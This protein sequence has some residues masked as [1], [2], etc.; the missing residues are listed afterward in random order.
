MTDRD[1]EELLDQQL[2]KLGTR[3]PAC[4]IEGCGATN[5]FALTGVDPN[6][7]CYE[8]QALLRGRPWLEEHHVAGRS[9]DPSTVL[10]P[11]N[12]HRVLSARQRLW[13]RETLRNP[14][15]SPLLRAAAALRGWL[16][17]L[18][19][20]VTCTVGWIPDLLEQLDAWLR[21]TLGDRWWDGFGWRKP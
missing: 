1:W 13:P 12:G 3:T 19:L 4:R 17:I 20:V 10:L 21:A 15:G 6:I 11:G 2:R 16:D 8:H 7:V 5:P 14:D 9:N 18:W